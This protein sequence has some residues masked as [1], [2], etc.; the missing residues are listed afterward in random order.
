[1]K[2]KT[3]KDSFPVVGMTCAACVAHVDKALRKQLGVGQV[4]VN[5][6]ANIATVEYDATQC[7]PE[8][9]QQ[10]VE[11]AGYGLVIDKGDDVLDEAEKAREKYLRSL[12]WRTVFALSL[13][14]LVMVLAMGFKSWRF[15]GYAAWMLATPVVFYLGRDF[16]INSWRL[17]RHGAMNMDTLVAL[18]TGIAY[19]FSLFNLLFP[20]VWRRHGILP[21]L[22]FESSSMIIGF[23]LLGRW[24]EEKA[25]GRTNT[26]V[27]KL[28]GLRPKTVSRIEAD[29]SMSMVPIE[30]I[31]KGDLM[32]VKPGERIAVD[33]EIV[34]GSSFVDEK[35]LSGE[36]IPVAKQ[37]GSKV[38]AGTINGK[39][40]FTFKAEKVGDETVLSH[41]IRAV[42]EAQGSKA[43]VQKLADK[44]AAVFV[45]TILGIAVLTLLLWLLLD[46]AE[47]L[48]H[49]LLAMVTVMIIACPC[50]LGLATPT[51]IM[52][53]IGLGAENGILVK[54]AKSLEKT[55]EMDAIVLDK[56]GTLTEGM[57]QVLECH[58]TDG[59]DD[60]AYYQGVF[61]AMESRSE[62]PL[63][64]A[65]VRY[66]GT[67]NTVEVSDFQS[68]TG[69]G[70]TA[71]CDGKPF[72][73]GN[74][75]LMAAQRI[76]VE[77]SLQAQAAELASGAATV[78]YFA[79]AERV[80][81]LAGVS[82]KVKESSRVAIAQL[83]GAGMEVHLLTGDNEATARAIAKDLNMAHFQANVLPEEKAHYVKDLQAKGRKVA[84]VGDGINDSAALA[85]ADISIAMGNGSDIAIDVAD[86]TIISSDMTKIIAAM[87]LS[88]LTVRTIRQNLFWAFFY[89]LISVPIAAG[90]LYPINGFLLNPM[91][92]GAAM[93]LS[94]VTVVSNSLRLKRKRLS[95]GL[96]EEESI[97]APLRLSEEADNENNNNVQP[98]ISHRP[99]KKYKVEGMMC[100]NCRKHVEKAL[101]GIEGVTATVSLESAEACLEFSDR[102]LSVDEL[103][104]IL[105]EEAGDYKITEQ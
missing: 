20:Q 14:A 85:Q 70:L 33:G 26:A 11:N 56:T 23:I 68:I 30:R 93:A 22:Y 40:G 101:N 9:L 100:Q 41:I 29:G 15:S 77:P 34:S 75:R 66:F 27:K 59:L 54:D 32:A 31:C 5:L 78:V 36:P 4:A 83:R 13:S 46:P 48:S 1:M 12:K 98:I 84:M 45:P 44:I 102:E 63:A 17:I 52:V 51:A 86:M 87:Q 57:P 10:A 81:A 61:S 47:G 62:H 50:A 103:Q 89:N 79:D 53:G 80:I 55:K 96:S 2:E 67:D 39:G 58:W 43:P 37:A 64:A 19:L 7:S 28:I 82:D 88:K 99:M 21:H 104:Q 73:I 92:G 38:Y 74:S 72:Y 95:Q 94:S 24:L 6:A 35:M 8:I 3:V 60:K 90:V 16:F 65:V 49:G 91:I 25:K 105:T 76:P 42:T 97:I 18:S 69:Q 71:F